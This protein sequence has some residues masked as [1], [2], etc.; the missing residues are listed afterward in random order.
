MAIVLKAD[1][2][3]G[4]VFDM[5]SSEIATFRDK[6]IIDTDLMKI[7][8]QLLFDNL[9]HEFNFLA[10]TVLVVSTDTGEA[11]YCKICANDDGTFYLS[12]A[13]QGEVLATVIGVL[14][15]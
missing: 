11:G 9:D 4:V 6:D 10:N 3:Y 2:C 14:V 1:G 5:L 15:N 12:R 7:P 8:Y 13:S